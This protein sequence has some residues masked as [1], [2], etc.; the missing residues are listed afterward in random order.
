[1]DLRQLRTFR[2][3][4]ERSSFTATARELNLTQPAVSAQIQALESE[5]GIRLFDRLPRKVRLTPIGVL[6]LDYA[7]RLLNLEAEARRAITDA[8]GTHGQL[9]RIGASPTIGEYI[10]PRILS[11]FRRKAPDTRVVV[12]IGPT[13]R[14]IE[15][16]HLHSVDVGMVEAAVDSEELSVESFGS[17]ELVL[18]ASPNHPWA[19]RNGIEAA[20]LVGEALVTREPGS[21]TREQ[22]DVA[23]ATHGVHIQ[24]NLELG[25]IESIK[26]AVAL[27]L[28]VSFVS[29]DAVRL[30][31]EAKRLVVID[32]PELDLRRP[33]FCVRNRQRY[34][35]PNLRAFLKLLK[36]LRAANPLTDET[37]DHQ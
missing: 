17:D 2:T 30:E 9:L 7:S 24:P 34:P 16:L 14:V 13:A 33:L 1:M 20:E 15:A 11:E 28:G 6:L 12:E 3:L 27:G 36:D 21:G 18:I 22:I 10:L 37:T 35:S 29:R 32:V 23:L 19:R 25:G 31:V 4:A 26:N 8:A 5:L